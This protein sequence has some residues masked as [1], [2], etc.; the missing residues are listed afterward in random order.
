VNGDRCLFVQ[1][2]FTWSFSFAW[3]PVD[4]VLKKTVIFFFPVSVLHLTTAFG[5]LLERRHR[6]CHALIAGLCC[7]ASDT[8]LPPWRGP[9]PRAG[10]SWQHPLQRTLSMTHQQD[11]SPGLGITTGAGVS[12]QKPIVPPRH[13]IPQT[14][15]LFPKAGALNH[16]RWTKSGRTAEA[17]HRL[18]W[19][20]FFPKAL[21]EGGGLPSARDKWCLEQCPCLDLCLMQLQEYFALWLGRGNHCTFFTYISV[22]PFPHLYCL[23]TENDKKSPV[24][25]DLVKVTPPRVFYLCWLKVNPYMQES[26]ASAYWERQTHNRNLFSIIASQ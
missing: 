25:E 19:I 23:A 2:D 22:L 6:R 15:V 17:W 20:A 24:W 21:D 18:S 4:L 5:E 12:G 3:H 14:A 26:D 11:L 16:H 8:L 1:F 10:R 9:D 13:P 7:R